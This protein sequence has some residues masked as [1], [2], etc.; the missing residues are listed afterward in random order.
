MANILLLTLV[1]GIVNLA[2]G[3]ALAAR[4]GL[5]PP[6]LDDAWQAVGPGK[7]LQGNLDPALLLTSPAEI[8]RRVREMLGQV[9]GRPGYIANL[10]HGVLPQTPVE[11]VI[12][13]VEAVHELGGP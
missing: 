10:G 6:T 4:L 5:A 12:A 2:L 1:I 3:Y 9:A 8:R 13:M 11:N 7:A